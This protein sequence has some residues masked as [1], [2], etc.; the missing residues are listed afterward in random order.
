MMQ[1]TMRIIDYIN[2]QVSQVVSPPELHDVQM[3]KIDTSITGTSNWKIWEKFDLRQAK[4]GPEL[5]IRIESPF[6][7]IPD[8]KSDGAYQFELDFGNVMVSSSI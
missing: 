1:K 8:L 7:I 6:V 3:K 5:N 4:Q 2:F